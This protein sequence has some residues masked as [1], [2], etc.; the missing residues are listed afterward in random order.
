[1]LRL[2]KLADYGTVIMVHLTQIHPQQASAKEIA[3]AIHI[4]VPTVAKILKLFST[5]GLLTST[6]GAK[7]GYTLA[8]AADDISVTEII[9]AVDGTTGL[10]ECSTHD[11]ECQIEA[12]CRI[13]GNWQLINT[14][15]MQALANIS[16]RQLATSNLPELELQND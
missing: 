16:L 13:R 15:V 5:S 10:T 11:G 3:N 8:R 9:Q 14:V 12:V 4:P 7:G 1:M 6:R 2:S